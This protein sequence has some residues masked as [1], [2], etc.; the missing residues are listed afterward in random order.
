[1]GLLS[2]H[3]AFHVFPIALPSFSDLICSSFK[4]FNAIAMLTF[5]VWIGKVLV[6]IAWSF[7]RVKAQKHKLSILVHRLIN[8]S[9][10]LDNKIY[11]TFASCTFR[12]LARNFS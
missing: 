2:S 3:A 8:P 4:K 7:V 12:R 10:H 9:T 11:R 5:Q 6:G 1:M